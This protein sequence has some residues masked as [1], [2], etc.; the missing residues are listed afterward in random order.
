MLY[1]C[2][3][4]SQEVARILVDL[5]GYAS[6][7]GWPVLHEV[8]DLAPP[9]VP[10]CRR[11]GWCTVEHLAQRGEVN[12]VIA[13]AV[14]EIAWTKSEQ[15]T[16]RAWLLGAA[17]CVLCPQDGLFQPACTPVRPKEAQA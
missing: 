6:A 5:R 9:A 17:V 10:R 12:A 2:H 14:R 4:N 16:L 1:T 3:T 8:Y 11:I 15:I 13:P 7:C